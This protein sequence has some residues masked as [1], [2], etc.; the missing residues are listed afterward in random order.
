MP[1]PRRRALLEA[2]YGLDA[3]P[4]VDRRLE[5]LLKQVPR[6]P[7]PPS[8]SERDAILIT[9][10]DQV[11][12]PGEP[13]LQTL[14]LF[15]DRWLPPGVSGVHVLPFH[16]YTSDDGFSVVDY[17]E[18]DP[19]L[20]T[21]ENIE[22]LGEGRRLMLDMVANHVSVKSRWFQGFLSGEAPYRDYFVTAPAGADVRSVVRPRTHPLL[23]PFATPAGE[24][25]VWTTFSDDQV[26]LD[27]HNPD[28][29]LEMVGV[30]LRYVERGASMIRLDAIAYTWKE[31][32]TTCIHLKG[33]H[34][35]VR[36]FRAVLD[37]VA[38]GVAL[39]TETNVSHTENVSYFGDGTNEASV[40]YNFALPVLVLQAFHTESARVLADWANGL[41][42]PG[43]GT[44]FL[45]FLASHDGIGVN[46]ARG[47][48]AEADIQA[49]GERVRAHGGFV[50]A[51]ANPDGTTSIYELNISY[52]DALSNPAGS[53]S[54][55]VQV[56]KFLTAHAIAL[57]LRGV[58]AVYVHSLF[59]SRSW[60]EGVE[61][62]GRSRT[63][64]REKWRRDE[65]ERDLE[66]PGSVRFE[67][68][69]G[70]GRL[71][72]ARSSLPELAPAAPQEVSAPAEGVMAI[73]RG[74]V[75]CLHNVSS[76]EAT[77]STGMK[78]ARDVLQ[79][80]MIGGAEVTLGPYES[81][82]LVDD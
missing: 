59:G 52:F 45:N 3:A 8:F 80:A 39:V 82:W 5:D 13:P 65:V 23:T 24:R 72:G 9:Y 6:R 16:P 36:L 11:T 70:M 79:V 49:L 32:G 55:D 21:W 30:L 18:V 17:G 77:I 56:R 48:V 74:R 28:V 67:V 69:E 38:P 40:V 7:T 75:L 14:A 25:L 15:C 50:S 35:L 71:F 81:R 27:Y 61:A 53:E 37:E 54:R 57:A 68:Y 63:I 47:I 4:A 58:P 22:R 2:L 12:S 42:T 20:G 31:P 44:A 19:A 64:N 78:A 41:A 66:Q 33:A 29:L 76:R 34:N 62:S 26:D 46:A 60:H 43:H 1:N 73:R 51:R 10:G